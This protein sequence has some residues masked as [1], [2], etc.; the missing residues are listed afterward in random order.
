M[1]PST[2]PLQM[3]SAEEL[4]AEVAN[5][6]TIHPETLAATAREMALAF[7]SPASVSHEET[8]ENDRKLHLD[9]NGTDAP[10]EGT[11][12][13]V[14]AGGIP[15]SVYRPNS[16]KSENPAVMVYFHGGG[17]MRGSR[18]TYDRTIKALA[19][20]SGVVIVSVEYRLLPCPGDPMAPFDDALAATRWAM[21]QRDTLGGAGSKV[22]VG[23]DSAGGQLVMG[24]THDIE[25]GLDFMVL[26][27]PTADFNLDL[28]SC[29]EFHNTPALNTA[30]LRWRFGVTNADIPDAEKN[31]RV[32]AAAREVLSSAPPAVVLLAQLDPLRDA[33]THLAQRLKEAGV[34]VRLHTLEGVPHGFFSMPGVYPSNTAQAYAYISDF[35]Q[36][37]Q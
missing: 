18:E 22:G 5:T 14:D 19:E 2:L 12:E 16:R 7:P 20:Q 28:P 6:Y 23:G 4:W 34:L 17:L 25:S 30:A 1:S 8:R 15:A 29:K 11:V 33:G 10:F 9:V 13:D 31:A 26:V 36:K 32:N 37:F 27:Y 24:V 35:L 3:S 21:K